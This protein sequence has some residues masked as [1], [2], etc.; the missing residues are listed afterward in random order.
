MFLQCGVS[1][2]GKALV[3]THEN[4]KKER[5]DT[6]LAEALYPMRP[7]M[8]LGRAVAA[9]PKGRSTFVVFDWWKEI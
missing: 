8:V 7:M 6:Y 2:F 9:E 1:T 4:T 3:I 5:W